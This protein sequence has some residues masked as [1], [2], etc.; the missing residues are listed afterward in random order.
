MKRKAILAGVCVP[1]PS[2]RHPA[3]PSPISRLAS[4]AMKGSPAT[5]VAPAA[6]RMAVSH[7]GCSAM[8]ASRA[9]RAVTEFAFPQRRGNLTYITRR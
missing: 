7:R 8:R 3:P 1:R 4:S 5:R 6:T 2:P 9:T